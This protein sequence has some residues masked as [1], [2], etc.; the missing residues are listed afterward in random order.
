MA[1]SLKFVS[2]KSFCS[3]LCC[4]PVLMNCP[5]RFTALFAHVPSSWD[6]VIITITTPPKKK[7]VC[8]LISGTYEWASNKGELRLQVGLRL[9]ISCLEM[10]KS[11]WSVWVGPVL[12]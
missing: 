2:C 8:A 1:N 12:P 5:L 6:L 3:C 4:A 10:R 9:L 11:P 7:D